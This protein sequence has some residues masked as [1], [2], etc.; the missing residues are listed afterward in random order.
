GFLRIHKA[1]HEL[2]L[3]KPASGLEWRHGFLRIHKAAHELKLLKPAS[4]LEWRHGFLI[5]P[6]WLMHKERAPRGALF[7]LETS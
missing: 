2:K 1:A 5:Q 6:T 4:G 7:V 3:L